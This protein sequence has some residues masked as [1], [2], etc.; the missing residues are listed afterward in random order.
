MNLCCSDREYE[1]PTVSVSTYNQPSLQEIDKRLTA[2]EKDYKEIY[3]KINK[4]PKY[5]E[6]LERFR[7]ERDEHK[8]VGVNL[9]KEIEKALDNLTT[10][11]L[12]GWF[13]YFYEIG[14]NAKK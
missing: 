12:R 2:L 3:K 9:E 7:D 14:L 11:D 1:T 6:V 4:S 10:K 8:Q 5:Q 13:R